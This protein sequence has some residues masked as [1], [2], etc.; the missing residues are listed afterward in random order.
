MSEEEIRL[1]KGYFNNGYCCDLD[2]LKEIANKMIDQLQQKE[3]TIKEV[4]EYIKDI[5]DN[6][7][8]RYD[9]E[10]YKMCEELLE[11]LDKGE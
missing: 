8:K 3:N 4:R 5:K 6:Y 10:V 9:D 7:F 11:I 2:E 1:I